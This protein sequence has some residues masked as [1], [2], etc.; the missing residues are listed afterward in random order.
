M[1]STLS[2]FLKYFFALFSQPGVPAD[3]AAPVKDESIAPQDESVAV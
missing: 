2:L 1:S 3:V